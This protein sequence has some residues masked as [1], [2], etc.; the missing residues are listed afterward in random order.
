MFSVTIFTSAFPISFS[1][2][3]NIPDNAS[4][5]RNSAFLNHSDCCDM[6]YSPD[7][8]Q[9]GWVLTRRGLGAGAMSSSFSLS[10]SASISGP[11]C[12]PTVVFGRLSCSL[13]SAANDV[14]SSSLFSSSECF[15]SSSWSFSGCRASPV[16]TFLSSWC[17]DGSVLDASDA[18]HLSSTAWSFNSTTISSSSSPRSLDSGVISPLS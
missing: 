8:I 14:E 12:S 9:L 6:T 15:L 17:T 3:G 7:R 18:S 16:T 13:V 10:D 1:A 2:D 11:C 4:P 5:L